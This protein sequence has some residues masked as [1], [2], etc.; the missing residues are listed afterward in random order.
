MDAPKKIRAHYVL[1]THWDREWYQ[2][3]QNYRYQLVRLIDRI[4][5]GIESGRLRGPFQTDGQA[6]VLEDY[7]E[8]RPERRQDIERF[9][10]AGKLV[11]GPWYCLPD[12]FLVSGESIIR[13]IRLG[14]A[15]ARSFDTK[16]SQAGFVCDLFGH[17][18]QM[19]QVFSGFGI[20]GALIWRG[21]NHVDSRHVRWRSPD[22]TQVTAYRF[23][24]FGYCDYAFKIRHATDQLLPVES[25]RVAGDVAAY[26]RDEA[27]HT[28]VDPILLFDGGDHEEWDQQAYAALFDYADHAE[29]EFEIVHTSLDAYL[30]EVVEQTSRVGAVVE[31]EL[32]EPGA[33]AYDTQWVIPGVLSSRVWIKQ[34]NARCESLLCAWAEPASTWANRVL[35]VEYPQGFLDVAWK[36]L[37]KNHPHDSIC[38]CSIDVVHEDMKYRFSQTEQIT[39]RL[40]LEANRGIAACVSGDVSDNE[41]RVVV[42]NPLATAVESTVELS[43]EIPQDWLT[44]NEFFGFEPKP[45]FYIYGPDDEPIPYQR[46]RQTNNR[47]KTRIYET[48]FPRRYQTNDVQ[49]SLPLHLPANGYTTLTV[50]AAPYGQPTRHPSNTGMAVSDHVM[51]NENL[52]VIVNANGSLNL[53]DKRSGQTYLDLLTFEDCADIGDGWYHGQAVNDEVFTSAARSAAVALVHDGPNLTTFRIRTTLQVPARFDFGDAMARSEDLVDLVLES[54]ISL[55]PG[56]TELEVETV[57]HNVAEDHRLRVLFPTHVQADTYLSDTPFDVVE[58]AIA[59][60]A[61]NYRYRELE[62]ETKPQQS[63]T[64]VFEEGRGLAVVSTGLMESAVRDIPERTLALTLLR[65]TRRTVGTDGQPDGLLLGDYAFRYK[66]APLF[67]QPDRVQLFRSGQLLA[68]GLQVVQ[69]RDADIRLHRRESILPP[70]QSFL[71]VEGEVVVTSAHMVEDGFEVRLFN[72]TDST[73]EASL[74]LSS[75]LGFANCHPVDLESNRLGPSTNLRSGVATVDVPPRK[76]VTLRFE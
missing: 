27:E 32:R 55:R 10:R 36:W 11:I 73:T 35:G 57:V 14:R 62:V 7:L 26:L 1:S 71:N 69:L 66:I 30:A 68:A 41:L 50:R 20:Q 59:L 53:V 37:L 25:Q 56:A 67:D 18:S 2:S 4:L 61:D 54:R 70:E 5:D 8:I 23:P 19:P 12:E 74:A 31:G 21:I 76:I 52:R 49:V 42:F 33:L 16:P 48:K 45:A 40:T 51:E 44:F 60:S 47:T 6:I 64:A 13:N 22:G 72:P 29:N 63:W 24:G 39:E 43:L 15:I 58:R 34:R 75:E 3:F 28:E 38:G 65:S 46:L 17:N 9:A